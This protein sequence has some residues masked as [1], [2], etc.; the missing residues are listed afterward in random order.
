[1]KAFGYAEKEVGKSGLLDLN[2]ITLVGTADEIRLVANFLLAMADDMENRLE[3]FD[4]RH[5]QDEVTNWDV[6]WPDFIVAASE[7]R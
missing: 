1:M 3:E 2:E 6:D 4:H 7:E 5:M